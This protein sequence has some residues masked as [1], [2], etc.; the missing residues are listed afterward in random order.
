LAQKGRFLFRIEFFPVQFAHKTGK[1]VGLPSPK[2]ALA[3]RPGGIPSWPGRVIPE[4]WFPG[5]KF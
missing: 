4:K 3:C 2:P 1:I 5:K